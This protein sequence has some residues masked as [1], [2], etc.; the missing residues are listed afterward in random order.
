MITLLEARD[1]SAWRGDMLLLDRINLLVGAGQVLQITG[2][3]GSGKTTLLRILCGLGVADEG[4]VFWQGDSLHRVRDAYHSE[5]LYLGHKPGIKGALTPV[6]NLSLFASLANV[7]GDAVVALAQLALQDKTQLPCHLLSAG[8]QRRVALARL[9]LQ[10][11]KLWI[12]DEPLMALDAMGR[13]WVQSQIR[14]Q[15]ARAGAVVFTTHQTLPLDDVCS[16]TL[17]LTE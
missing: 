2:S 15:I 7:T 12:L 4:E 14:N 16:R 8:Q 5:L 9:V 3:N 11:A 10:P 1:I 13:S 17:A 6:E